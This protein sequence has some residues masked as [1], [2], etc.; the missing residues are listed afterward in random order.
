[1]KLTSREPAV[2][3]SAETCHLLNR[4][5]NLRAV[6]SHVRDNPR[7]AQEIADIRDI[8]AGFTPLPEVEVTSAEVAQRLEQWLTPQAVADLEGITD[9]AVRLA[10]TEGRIEAEQVGGRW[11]IS[12]TAYEQYRTERSA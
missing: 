8:G 2:I 5:F 10:C 12:Q 6:H 1:M 9:R 3:V 4:I 7:V 11:Q